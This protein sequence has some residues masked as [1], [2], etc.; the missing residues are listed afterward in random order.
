M[1]D[2]DNQDHRDINKGIGGGNA[3]FFIRSIQQQG[4]LLPGCEVSRGKA[5]PAGCAAGYHKTMAACVLHRHAYS[6]K[7]MSCKGRRGIMQLQA[8]GG[9]YST[10]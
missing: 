3:S 9:T 10:L 6:C 1:A 5:S 2:Q 7:P 8:K 4:C